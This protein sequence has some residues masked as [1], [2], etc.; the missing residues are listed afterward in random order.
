[1]G[2]FS[3]WHWAIVLFALAIPAAIIGLVIWFIVR[4]SR[5]PGGVTSPAAAPPGAASAR[6]SAE[7]R[8]QELAGLKSQGLITDSE[9]ENRRSAILEGV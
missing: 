7:S 3:L 6:P 2:S 8:L 5:R 9:Y 1:M 4:A